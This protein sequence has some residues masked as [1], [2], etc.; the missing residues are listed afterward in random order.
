MTA[1]AGHWSLRPWEPALLLGFAVFAVLYA[2]STH[3]LA[4]QLWARDAVIGYVVGASALLALPARRWLLTLAHG[5][6]L[7]I[8]LL[9]VGT[10]VIP[11]AR[12]VVD[13]VANP[14]IPILTEAAD[15]WLSVGTPF[16]TEAELA[17][18]G[19]GVNSYNVY[20]PLLAMFGLPSALFGRSPVTDPRIYLALVCFAI[21][22]WL[23]RRASWLAALFVISPA[24]ALQLVSG[25]TDIP[26]LGFV[27]IGL[28][29]AG[30]DRF[31]GAGVA[32]GIAAGFKVLAW[33]AVAIALILVRA[34]G[35][36]RALARCAGIVAA[37]L[38]PVLGLPVLVDP[39]AFVVNAI[40]LPL[41]VLPVKLTA[42]SP[43]PGHLLSQEGPAGQLIGLVLLGGAALAIGAAA[44]RRPPRD[45]AAA[46]RWIA[47][48]MLVA[49][50]LAP[51]T[52]YGYLVYSIGLLLL[53]VL[54]GDVAVGERSAEQAS[55]RSH[56]S[57][58]GAEFALLRA[59]ALP[60]QGPDPGHSR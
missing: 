6:L 31:G 55:F 54:V 59:P 14:E 35:G 47:L 37:V 40:K 28:V 9:V 1:R 58:G 16:P 10:T 60:D 23:G 4:H 50:L 34:R 18:Q 45:A 5:H 52:R 13:G 21:F 32:M 48:G 7:V 8:V 36:R 2:F 44:L 27:L 15:R 26:V 57:V 20:L 42:E 53:P 29:L 3:N 46:A 38:V 39:A 12:Q 24:V 22:L 30:R 33:P 11:L 49:V 43:L 51:A 17:S 25:G 56:E 19:G 41:G